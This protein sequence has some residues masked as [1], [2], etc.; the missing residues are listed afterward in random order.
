MNWHDRIGLTT[1]TTT[2]AHREEHI[3]STTWTT[4]SAG[5]GQYVEVNLDQHQQ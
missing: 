4:Q 5:T 2:T 1:M 3:V